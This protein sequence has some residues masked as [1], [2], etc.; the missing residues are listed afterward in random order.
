MICSI[1]STGFEKCSQKKKYINSLR[2]A[3]ELL[4]FKGC[5]DFCIPAAQ[6]IPLWTGEIICGMKEYLR[7]GLHIYF[8]YEAVTAGMPPKTLK[9]FYEMRSCADSCTILDRRPADDSFRKCDIAL[10]DVCDMLVLIDGDISSPCDRSVVKY[11]HEHNIPIRHE[12]VQIP[13]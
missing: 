3:T 12:I 5:R 1:L 7:V 9:E 2:S 4:Y 10:A 11:A 6:G 13:H 8:P